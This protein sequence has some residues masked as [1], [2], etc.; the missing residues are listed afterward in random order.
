MPTDDAIDAT[1]K[2]MQRFTLAQFSEKFHKQE[3]PSPLPVTRGQH[4]ASVSSR[5]VENAGDRDGKGV[6]VQVLSSV[7][8]VKAK[9]QLAVSGHRHHQSLICHHTG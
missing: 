2:Q 5:P 6:K 4:S 9:F 7:E 1:P 3:P 8:T